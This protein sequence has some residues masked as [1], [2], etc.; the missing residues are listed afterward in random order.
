MKE[1]EYPFD[2]KY[3]TK[4][5]KSLRRQLLADG[6]NR[7]SKKIAILGGSTTNEIMLCLELFLLNQGIEPSFYE[8][9][10]NMYWQ[11]AILQETY[12]HFATIWE[13]LEETFHCPIRITSNSPSIA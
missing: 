12:A 2:S 5:K 8:S 6:S 13:H 4:K 1:L 7:I 3:I 9:E 10:Y 11:D